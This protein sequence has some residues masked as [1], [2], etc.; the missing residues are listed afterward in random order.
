MNQKR[1]SGLSNWTYV[2]YIVGTQRIE[3]EYIYNAENHR[4]WTS[5]S[6]LAKPKLDQGHA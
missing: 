5:R 1:K 3:R 2:K 6:G 4:E